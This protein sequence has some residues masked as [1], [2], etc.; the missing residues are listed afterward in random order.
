MKEGL[1]PWHWRALALAI[2]AIAAAPTAI[3]HGVKSRSIEIVH[4]WVHETPA[5][6]GDAAIYM[7][8]KG[9]GRSGDRLVGATTTM[10]EAVE[11]RLPDKAGA[12]L[13]SPVPS[14]A[15]GPKARVELKPGGPHLL[16]RRI[17]RPLAAYDSFRLTLVFERAGR[18]EVEVLVE[19]AA[20]VA[21]PKH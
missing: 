13:T 7:V 20:V 10:A 19:E 18:I 14:I 11:F 9:L 21:P 17:A 8:L 6:G 4:P 2:A 5:A 15:A 1:V 12:P 16:M 3:G